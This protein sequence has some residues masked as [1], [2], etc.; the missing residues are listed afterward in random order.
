LPTWL[1][2]FIGPGAEVFQGHC[3]ARYVTQDVINC[4][5]LWQ[6]ANADINHASRRPECP[7][8]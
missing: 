3:A 6:A 8:E 1:S 5:H 2:E 4:D 7:E